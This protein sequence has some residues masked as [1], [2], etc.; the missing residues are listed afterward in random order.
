VSGPTLRPRRNRSLTNVFGRRRG[1]MGLIPFDKHFDTHFNVY[2]A[3]IKAAL[4]DGI[5][6][7]K[8]KISRHVG[9]ITGRCAVFPG[10][11]DSPQM[12][13][14][15][16]GLTRRFLEFILLDL[17]GYVNAHWLN[18]ERT[19][20]ACLVEPCPWHH[21]GI[22]GVPRSKTA[23]G[24]QLCEL[25]ADMHFVVTRYVKPWTEQY[26]A[27]LALLLNAGHVARKASANAH[28]LCKASVFI[29]HC[30]NALFMDFERTLR[31]SLDPETSVW[32]CSFALWQHG[33]IAADLQCLE[34]CSFVVAL[35]NAQRVLAITDVTV[36]TFDRCW[37]V[38]EAHIAMTSSK[39]Y[40]ICL[41]EDG[42]VKSWESAGV[43]LQQLDV[44]TC[45]ATHNSD[46]RAILDFAR[47]GP[48]G[49]KA[50]NAHVR[51]IAGIAM[52]RTKLMA[53]AAAGDVGCL[54]RTPVLE[55]DSWR[56]LQGRTATHIAAM[57]SNTMA[58]LEILGRTGFAHMDLGDMNLRT[59]LSFAAEWGNVSA[60]QA[61]IHAEA[62][63]NSASGAGL[64]PLHYAAMT[65]QSTIVLELLDAKANIEAK[66]TYQGAKEVTPIFLAARHGF[67]E[68]ISTL[69]KENADLEARAANGRTSLASAVTWGFA[70][71]TSA[72]IFAQADVNRPVTGE[73][74][75][76]PL[77]IAVQH[78]NFNCACILLAS[79]A[80]ADAVSSDGLTALD[81]C[82]ES[83]S[84][85]PESARRMERLLRRFVG[86]RYALWSWRRHYAP[87]PR[88]RAA[89]CGC[90]THLLSCTVCQ[91]DVLAN[92]G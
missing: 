70:E 19:R 56:S 83:E 23:L 60:A 9:T 7:S 47:V 12:W 27:G 82:K 45:K 84:E 11:K 15:T 43:K 20:H 51:R 90:F 22:E 16:V 25:N 26:G 81:Y 53:A 92:A 28:V 50:L 46:K 80:T 85:D 36:E 72:L 48:G 32:V 91:G 64:T 2:S 42:D 63:V 5:T 1:L 71:A 67:S 75:R 55:L 69:G 57:S 3:C 61:L 62:S 77:M 66:C 86:T 13:G 88:S 39:P 35:K 31:N 40:D 10:F 44:E 79:D 24:T 41:P 49:V 33:D 8:S 89:R 76:T 37:C 52:D 74:E 87:Q 21:D 30:W 73:V 18:A 78:G 54:R 6:P 65:G 29:S 58:M 17:K 38:L 34:N 4:N 59:P 68:V 14:M